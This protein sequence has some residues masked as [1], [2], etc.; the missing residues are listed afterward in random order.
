MAVE[1]ARRESFGNFG[2]E[3]SQLRYPEDRP[4]WGVNA[5]DQE[6]SFCTFQI[7]APAHDATAKRLGLEEYKTDFEQCVQLA[8]A[9]YD[10]AGGFYPWTEYHKILAM[11]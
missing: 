1:V 4:D 9:I 10:G 5:G 7:H 11:R 3:Q 2:M 6:L 8:R